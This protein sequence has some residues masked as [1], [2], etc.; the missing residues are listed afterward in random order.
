LQ[1]IINEAVDFGQFIKYLFHWLSKR[2]NSVFGRTSILQCFFL[3]TSFFQIATGV[4][5]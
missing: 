1:K 4:N 2:A 5:Y 3:T